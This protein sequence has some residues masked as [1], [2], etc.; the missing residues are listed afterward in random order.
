MLLYSG[1][2]ISSLSRCSQGMEDLAGGEFSHPTAAVP[3]RLVNLWAQAS[4][5]PDLR[6]LKHVTSTLPG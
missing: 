5:G 4:L 6:G 1:N 3:F 2:E